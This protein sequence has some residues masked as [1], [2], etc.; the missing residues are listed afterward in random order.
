[1]LCEVEIKPA[2]NQIDREGARILKECQV[3]GAHSIRSVLT[4]HSYLLEGDL[5]QSDLENIAQSLLSDPVVETFEIRILS[6][7]SSDSAEAEQ[8]LNVLFKPGVTDN[9]AN[10]AREAIRDLGHSV[11]NVAT[12]RKY[13]I[14]SDATS[15]EADRMA[16]KVLS[17]DA[18]EQVVR[19]PLCMNSIKL[20]SEYTFELVTIP[21]RAMNNQQL[22]TLSRE[23]QLY[24][25]LTEM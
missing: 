15:E 10:S 8:L 9:V 3:L 20:G 4:A 23:G 19:G 22:E 2:E 6:G 13:W 5:N 7:N 16:S 12:C 11:E 18:I 24:L 1:M 17:N 21:I 14:N 25:N